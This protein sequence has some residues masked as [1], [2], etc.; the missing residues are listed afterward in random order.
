M[1]L[2]IYKD[3]SLISVYGVTFG[4]IVDPFID[5]ICCCLRVAEVQS[6]ALTLEVLFVGGHKSLLHGEILLAEHS[7]CNQHDVLVGFARQVLMQ[8]L[9]HLVRTCADQENFELFLQHRL[10]VLSIKLKI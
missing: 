4:L 3:G 5:F 8:L 9:Q 2:N 6:P 10:W 7:I 1:P